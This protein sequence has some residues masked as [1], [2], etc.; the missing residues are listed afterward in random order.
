MTLTFQ[1]VLKK[2]LMTS[3][4]SKRGI[5]GKTIPAGMRM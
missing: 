1:V 3:A 4:P 2:P 5:T